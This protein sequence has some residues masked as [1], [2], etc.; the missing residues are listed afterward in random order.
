[1]PSILT[2]A[3][4]WVLFLTALRFAAVGAHGLAP[5]AVAG[6]HYWQCPGPDK[7][8]CKRSFV[9]TLDLS[10][11]KLLASL[12]ATTSGPWLYGGVLMIGSGCIVGASNNALRY[13]D[14]APGWAH[15]NM[16]ASSISMPLIALGMSAIMLALSPNRKVSAI[17]S[18][19]FIVAGLGIGAA[20]AAMG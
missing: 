6:W 17:T 8:I 16:A 20:R 13:V 18:A 12:S 10:Y 11:M 5:V 9:N 3:L 2:T 19:V 14:P 7:A 15:V 4:V 1:M